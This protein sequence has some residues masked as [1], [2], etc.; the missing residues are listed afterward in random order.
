M[1]KLE[2]PLGSSHE[3]MSAV[4]FTGKVFD[5]T[6]LF[7]HSGISRRS[8]EPHLDTHAQVTGH[9][10]VRWA[11]QQKVLSRKKRQLWRLPAP[12]IPEAPSSYEDVMHLND[13]RQG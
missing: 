5:D 4:L 3:I 11:E 6:Y 13:E 1:V 10:Q 2:I 9:P 7:L 8:A 12:P